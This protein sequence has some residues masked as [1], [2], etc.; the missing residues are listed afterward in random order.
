MIL[1]IILAEITIQNIQENKKIK[2]IQ[3][4]EKEIKISVFVDDTT[5]YIGDNRSFPYLQNQLQDF[6][7]FLGV[8]YN[9]NKCFGMWL[10][11]N[12]DNTEKPMGFKWNSD[13]IK[14]LVYSEFP[15][16]YDNKLAQSENKNAK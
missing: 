11:V 2:G 1:Y 13:Q 16:Q 6:G 12:I 7:Q 14:I 4:L 15:R 9:R 8:K 5:L 10:G 3:V